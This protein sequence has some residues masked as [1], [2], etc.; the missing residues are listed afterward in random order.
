MKLAGEALREEAELVERLKGGD[1]DAF[2]QL[3]QRH[4][5][6][7]IA[8]AR[9]ILGDEDLAR[10]AVQDALLNAYRGIEGFNG[11]ARLSSWLHRIVANAAFAKIR[12]RRRRPESFLTE[13]FGAGSDDDPLAQ[14]VLPNAQGES[15][16]AVDLLERRQ[17][18]AFVRACIAHL[19]E[20]HRTV[21]TL[22]YIEEFDTEQ[23][24]RILGI[25]PN[26]VKTRLLRARDALR[27]YIEREVEHASAFLRL[28][29]PV[30]PEQRRAA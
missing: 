22:R 10:D 9:Q 12:R 17:E 11:D 19:R 23:T 24:A 2:E 7:L 5:G 15:E 29:I 4:S 3:V 16:S 14:T 8:L 20:K 1:E 26:T 25:A 28:P 27:A 13:A 21:L 18:C 30:E 6:R